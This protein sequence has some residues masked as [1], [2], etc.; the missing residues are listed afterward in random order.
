MKEEKNQE[1]KTTKDDVKK[2]K[3]ALRTIVVLIAVAVFAIA[4]FVSY[5]ATYLNVI[6][7]GQEYETIFNQKY[8]NKMRIFAIAAISIYFYI[9]INTGFIK[10]GLKKFFEEEK[11]EFPKL[12][13]KSTSLIL[14]LIGG[15]VATIMLADKYAIFANAAEF[16]QVDPVFGTALEYYMFIIPFV[17]E[18]LMYLI[19]VII[20]TIAYVAL[21]YVITLNSFFDGVDVETLKK[22]T[23]IKQEMFLI[24]VLAIVLCVYVF[25][26]AQNILTGNMLSIGEDIDIDIIGAGSADV[27]I[28]VW[29]YRLF[30]IVIF[31]AV[32]KLLSNVKKQNFKKGMMSIL[33]VPA[34]LVCLFVVIVGFETITV[35]NNEFDAEK[36]YIG[37]N[38]KNTKEAYG[39]DIEQKNID[40]YNTITLDQVNSNQEVI[41]NIP[42][43]NEDVTLTTVGEHQENSVY[44][45]YDRTSLASYEVDG[46]NKLIYLI[47]LYLLFLFY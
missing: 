30:S 17:Q 4:C 9:L 34:Y 6:S 12:P 47:L 3:I 10:K 18:L 26:G 29:G 22:N 24:M 28:K 39:I 25:V 44:Y 23:F 46:K 37:Y 15:V 5:R 11:K 7:V 2:S 31:I 8:E 19:G 14:A 42:V 1:V 35:T 41:N 45:S 13:G 27:L 33:M 32:A 16:G 40:D 38:I 21:Y 20:V 43:I 36:E